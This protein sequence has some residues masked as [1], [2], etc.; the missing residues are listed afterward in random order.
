MV[1]LVLY[2]GTMP[3]EVI[4]TVSVSAAA[5][6]DAKVPA[7]IAFNGGG[8]AGCPAGEPGGWTGTTLVCA[9]ATPAARGKRSI[10]RQALNLFST[11]IPTYPHIRMQ[12]FGKRKLVVNRRISS[13]IV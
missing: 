11:L 4:E 9:I 6:R 12:L 10:C 7:K 3:P 1:L 8:T 13:A 2:T 5:N